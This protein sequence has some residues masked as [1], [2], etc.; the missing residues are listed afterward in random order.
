VRARYIN[1]EHQHIK[2]RKTDDLGISLL[3]GRKKRAVTNTGYANV[4]GKS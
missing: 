4:C 1:S 3:G 2:M